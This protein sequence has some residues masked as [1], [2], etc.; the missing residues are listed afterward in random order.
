MPKGLQYDNWLSSIGDGRKG[1]ILA[2]V[3]L[4]MLL[5]VH[6]VLHLRGGK[7]WTTLLEVSTNHDELLKKYEVH[8][9]YIG[10]GL[11]IKLIKREVLLQ[12]LPDTGTYTVSLEFGELSSIEKTSLDCVQMVSLGVWINCKQLDNDKLETSVS[13]DIQTQEAQI[14][15]VER[16]P[17]TVSIHPDTTTKTEQKEAPEWI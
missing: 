14:T 5:E 11:L 17:K 15:K 2:L 13:A 4:S 10:C 3:R 8:L 6:T 9:V 1:N 16:K 7:I 12:I